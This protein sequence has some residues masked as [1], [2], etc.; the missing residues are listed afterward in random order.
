MN[1]YKVYI[2]NIKKKQKKIL[3]TKKHNSLLDFFQKNKIEIKYQCKK[4]YCGV[5]KIY[6]IKGKI[7]YHDTP[8]AIFK[9]NE[10]LPCICLPK[11]NINIHIK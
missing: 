1:N 3:N 4:G 9:K 11:S 6:L 7:I 2:S 8:I 5:C 10:I